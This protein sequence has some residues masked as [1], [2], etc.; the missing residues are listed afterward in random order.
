MCN[1]QEYKLR[2]SYLNGGK[3]LSDYINNEKKID[4]ENLKDIIIIMKELPNVI[5]QTSE[6]NK[7]ADVSAKENIGKVKSNRELSWNEK[8]NR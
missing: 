8:R 1:T 5:T 4:S 2:K 6:I 3:L 7:S